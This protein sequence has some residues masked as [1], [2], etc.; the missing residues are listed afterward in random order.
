[1]PY[2]KKKKASSKRPSGKK[3]KVVLGK[4][5]T[6]LPKSALPTR[7]HRRDP[8]NMIKDVQ[9][10]QSIDSSQSH[11]LYGK[12]AVL[13]IL[14]NNPK[15]VQKLY[16]AKTAS[17]K[18]PRISEITELSKNTLAHIQSVPSAKLDTLLEQE[19][20]AQGLVHQGIV[21]LVTAVPLL[22]LEEWLNQIKE[23][24]ETTQKGFV[25]A[26]DEVTDPHNIGAIIRVSEAMGALGLVL[27]RHRSGIISP[28]ASKAASGADRTLPLIQV[29]NLTQA[30]MTMKDYGFWILGADVS[31][32]TQPFHQINY[33]ELPTVIV[34]GS[35]G[36]GL[37]QGIK[38]AC[39][40]LGY[41]PIIG[42]VESLNVS[43]AAAIMTYE[44]AMQQN[45]EEDS[46]I[47]LVEEGTE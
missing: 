14:R 46:V 29:T 4:K 2:P 47:A 6:P 23:H 8:R 3:R 34:L 12:N 22:E 19:Q 17:S 44:V 5:G 13:E 33:T 32:E 43:T 24:V 10:T 38:D 31:P 28:V 1:M 15:R 16:M 37:R 40:M 27:P 30:L 39:D 21:A 41:I 25:V 20:E 9:N 45:R 18:D 26:I 42:Q 35:E 7:K 36:K 11:Y